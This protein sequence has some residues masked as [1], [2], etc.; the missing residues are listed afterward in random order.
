MGW[1]GMGAFGGVEVCKVSDFFF[2]KDWDNK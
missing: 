1:D 2:V